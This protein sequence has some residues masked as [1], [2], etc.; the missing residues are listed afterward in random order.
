MYSFWGGGVGGAVNQK[1]LILLCKGSAVKWLCCQSINLNL[2]CQFYSIKR[3][4]LLESNRVQT[5]EISDKNGAYNK[6]AKTYIKVVLG[7]T[8]YLTY[9]QHFSYVM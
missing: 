1:I 9:H 3:V 8:Y 2:I 4:V 7:Y 5:R 6:R